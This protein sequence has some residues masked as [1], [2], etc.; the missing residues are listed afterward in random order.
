MNLSGLFTAK[1]GKKLI[2]YTTL[3]LFW[4]LFI[5]SWQPQYLKRITINPKSKILTPENIWQRRL[6]FPLEYFNFLHTIF[7]V[8]Y[9]LIWRRRDVDDSIF[10]KNYNDKILQEDKPLSIFLSRS[11]FGTQR[12][13]GAGLFRKK[14][15]KKALVPSW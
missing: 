1:W 2:V 15:R 14:Y 4:A 7:F 13:S 5:W 8:Q 11:I 12:H 6:K 9:F 10:H 3:I